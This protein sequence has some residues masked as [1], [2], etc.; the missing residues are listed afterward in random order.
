MQF[1]LSFVCIVVIPGIAIDFYFTFSSEWNFAM[2]GVVA[3]SDFSEASPSKPPELKLPKG[4]IVPETWELP[5][6]SVKWEATRIDILLLTA[7][8]CEFLSCLAFLKP[9]YRKSHVPEISGYVYFGEIGSDDAELKIGVI[10]CSEGSGVAHGS[11]IVVPKAVRALHP[12]AVICVGYCA[13]FKDRGVKLGDVIIS[14]KLATYGPTKVTKDE[15]IKLGVE[16]PASPL[17]QGILNYADHGWKAPLQRPGD[18]TVHKDALLLSGPEVVSSDERRMELM[19]SYPKAIGLEMEGEGK[20]S[21][22]NDISCEQNVDFRQSTVTS[23]ASYSL[24]PRI[25]ILPFQ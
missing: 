24:V 13:G 11:T 12:K 22:N 14:S 19:Q 2:S 20:I 3:Q 23:L 8:E 1:L 18:V 17:F 9:G 6:I 10:Q 16:V 25:S 21:L 5:K 4:V 15:K 7:Q